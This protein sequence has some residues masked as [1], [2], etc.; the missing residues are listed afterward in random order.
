MVYLL[1]FFIRMKSYG[2][3]DELTK[4]PPIGSFAENLGES[5]PER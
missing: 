2:V 5:S 1:P 3:E 4:T